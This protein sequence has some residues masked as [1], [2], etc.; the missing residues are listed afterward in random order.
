MDIQLDSL[1]MHMFR[2]CMDMKLRFDEIT[3]IYGRNGSGKSTI[4]DAFAFAFTGMNYWGNKIVNPILSSGSMGWVEFDGLV[5]SSPCKFKRI[6]E[7]NNGSLK[8]VVNVDIDLDKSLFLSIINPK[9]FV[10]LSASEAKEVLMRA[11]NL[12]TESLSVRWPENCDFFEATNKLLEVT[13]EQSL[14]ERWKRVEEVRKEWSAKIKSLEEEKAQTQGKIDAYEQSLQFFADN[15]IA[16]SE[17]LDES[18]QLFTLAANQKL[19]N[20]LNERDQLKKDLKELESYKNYL[21]SLAVFSIESELDKTN[22]KLVGDNG[23]E[24]FVVTYKGRDYKSL[25]NSEQLMAGLEIV[26]ALEAVSNSN[27]PCFIDNAEALQVQDM[28]LYPSIPQIIILNVADVDLSVY[29]DGKLINPVTTSVMTRTKAT[30]VPN[31]TI[32]GG[33]GKK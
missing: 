19:C 26:N 25:S 16:V 27:L 21:V 8:T 6:L 30:L 32:I 22:I 15:G 13:E 18:I 31:V 28:S 7:E 14:L 9:Y 12:T 29:E 3:E 5:N 23:K 1:H 11:S 4:A 20:L 33:W 17:E 24:C 10:S 2:G